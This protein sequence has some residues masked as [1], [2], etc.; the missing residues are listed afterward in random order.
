MKII[1]QIVISWYL[2]KKFREGK[3]ILK[4]CVKKVGD[5]SKWRLMSNMSKEQESD[6][7][8]ECIL[9]LNMMGV[10]IYMWYE[11]IDLTYQICVFNI[12]FIKN[13]I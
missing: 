4:R 8:Q 11:Y 5:K 1:V 7:I 10:H 2:I 13:S 9:F 3:L 12:Q 6:T